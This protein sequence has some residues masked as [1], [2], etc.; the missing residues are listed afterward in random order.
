[1]NS[2]QPLVSIVTPCYEMNK[3]GA[4]YLEYSFNTLKSQTYINFE[5]VISDHSITDEIEQL[6]KKWKQDLN[7]L[8]HRNEHKRGNSSANINNA[9]KQAKGDIIKVLFQDD[10]LYNEN[11]LKNQLEHLKGNW[12]VTACCHYNGKELYRPFYPRYH[13]KIQYGNNT[14]SSPS[15]LMFRNQ[16]VIE[17]DENLIWLMDVDYYKMLYD[18][19]GDPDICNHISVVNRIHPNQVSSTL[20]TKE[21]KQNELNYLTKKYS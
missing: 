6:C 10:F 18:R 17:F 16:N 21:L 14:I 9:V 4:K 5:I 15:V 8:Y 13:D 3:K 19:F 12:L 2:N 11:S 7:I 20:A 1:M